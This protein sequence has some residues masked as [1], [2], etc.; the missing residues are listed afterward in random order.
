MY[1]R[2]RSRTAPCSH[3]RLGSWNSKTSPASAGVFSG[4]MAKLQTL[5]Q[6]AYTVQNGCCF[7][8]G[9]PMWE[10]ANQ[11]AFAHQYQL[12][13]KLL[14]LCQSTAEHLLAR[15]DGG[16]DAGHNIAA[17][18]RFCNAT[19]HKCGSASAPTPE[20]YKARV[21]QGIQ[22]GKWHPALSWLRTAKV[23]PTDRDRPSPALSR[24]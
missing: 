2:Y 5:R 17:A 19:R 15:Q 14:A 24:R 8:C 12:S 20:K 16:Q 4:S 21:Q 13:S 3:Q 7:Y 22:R 10:A 18:C 1:S 11:K 23:S 9:L 6:R